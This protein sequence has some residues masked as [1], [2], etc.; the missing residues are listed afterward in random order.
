MTT[1][2]PLVAAAALAA[3]VTLVLLLRVVL[4]RL[5][6]GLLPVA[7]TSARD[8]TLAVEQVLA[9]DTRRRLVLVRCDGRRL[10]LLTGGPQ[11]MAL[12]WLEP[13]A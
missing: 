9:L 7:I 3:V 2:T 1:T 10:L 12:G 11:D 4:P 6:R 13:G 5:P 8:G